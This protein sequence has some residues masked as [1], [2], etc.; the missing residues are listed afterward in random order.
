MPA[1][2]HSS[3]RV[4]AKV[5]C[6]SLGLGTLRVNGAPRGG[7]R[8]LG[9]GPGVAPRLHPDPGLGPSLP[10]HSGNRL[11]GPQPRP[12]RPRRQS[13]GAAEVAQAALRHPGIVSRLVVLSASAGIEDETERA[14]R[15]ARDEALARR[16][17][18][19]GAGA[20]LEEWL[21]QPLFATLPRD[22]AERAA[23]SADAA[24][25]ADSLRRAGTG[26]QAWLLEDLA[27]LEVPTLVLAGERDPKFVEA[28]TRLAGALVN[29]RLVVLEGLGH[30]AHLEDPAAVA[31]AVRDFLA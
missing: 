5:A 1:R 28:G 9:P 23:R 25:L 2:R 12:A 14:A 3:K 31:S 29:A 19:I 7:A 17:E 22:A 30:A 10:D 24:G 6:T 4:A 11:R 15:R 20:F 27:R 16:I 21:A 8:G 26:T 18:R 13:L